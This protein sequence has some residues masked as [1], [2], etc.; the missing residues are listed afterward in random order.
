MDSSIKGNNNFFEACNNED[1]I[2]TLIVRYRDDVDIIGYDVTIKSIY[3]TQ[4]L[5]ASPIFTSTISLSKCT[6]IENRTLYL[7]MS[8][9]IIF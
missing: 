1:N 3:H 8:D 9:K 2:D 4:F 6:A 7:V 5:F